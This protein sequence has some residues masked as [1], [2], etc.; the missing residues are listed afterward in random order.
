MGPKI[1]YWSFNVHVWSLPAPLLPGSPQRQAPSTAG[2]LLVD[3]FSIPSV[4]GG[5]IVVG[6]GGGALTTPT[7]TP[8]AEEGFIR[9]VVM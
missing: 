3:V 9:S 2:D 6:G 7:L 4:G 8:G 1:H 5:G